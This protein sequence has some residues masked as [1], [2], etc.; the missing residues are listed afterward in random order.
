MSESKNV[1]I[2]LS[3]FHRIFVFF[4]FLSFS[5]Y[6]K[7]PAMHEAEFNDILSELHTKQDSINLRFAYERMIHANGD[8]QR[9]AARHTYIKLKNQ[10]QL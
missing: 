1:Q 9:H 6:Y 10:K 5:S 3:L 2:P 8:E 4:E 7:V